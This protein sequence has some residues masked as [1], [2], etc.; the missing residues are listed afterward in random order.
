MSLFFLCRS[1]RGRHERGLALGL[2]P[3]GLASSF[4]ANQSF[5]RMDTARCRD[6][7]SYSGLKQPRMPAPRDP[8]KSRREMIRD[9]CNDEHSFS[10]NSTADSSLRMASKMC[11]PGDASIGSLGR[12]F[13]APNPIMTKNV[14]NPNKAVFVI[15]PEG[16]VISFSEIAVCLRNTLRHEYQNTE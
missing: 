1:G 7:A 3:R 13:A 14:L 2:T 6:H 12:S 9:L 5:P 16:K 8:L 15:D 4:E 11:L 10:F